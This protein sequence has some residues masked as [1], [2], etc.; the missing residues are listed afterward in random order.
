MSDQ[1]SDKDYKY[2]QDADAVVSENIAMTD[3]YILVSA[4]IFSNIPMLSTSEN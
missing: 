3:A 4:V 1:G 2:R